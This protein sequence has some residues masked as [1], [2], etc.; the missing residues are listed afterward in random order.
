MIFI[1]VGSREYQFDRLIIEMDYLLEK[2]K[3]TDMVFAQIGTTN[4]IPKSMD[5][6]RFMSPADFGK[7]Q[8]AASLIITHGGTGAI[9]SALKKE[10]QVIV[11]PR[12][13]EFGEHSDDHQLEITEILYKTGYVYRVLNIKELEF[14]IKNINKNPITKKFKSSSS[15]PTII[16]EFILNNHKEKR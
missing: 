11:V 13:S 12:L 5:Y 2:K 4:Y 15:V 1:S 14:C 7:M 6:A 8:D 10:K 16:R 3:I 9:I